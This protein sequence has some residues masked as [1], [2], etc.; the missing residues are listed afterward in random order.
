MYAQIK[1]A[2]IPVPCTYKFVFKFK[3]VCTQVAIVLEYLRA[4]CKLQ[5]VILYTHLATPI[6]VK[7]WVIK[8]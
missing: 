8:R 2:N 4:R 6:D 5:A 1:H 3:L 7:P